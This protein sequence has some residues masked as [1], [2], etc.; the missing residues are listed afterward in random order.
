MSEAYFLGVAVIHIAFFH[1]STHPS[2]HTG[3]DVGN[4]FST[5]NWSGSATLELKKTIN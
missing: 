3:G 5:S 2:T 1:L 4:S